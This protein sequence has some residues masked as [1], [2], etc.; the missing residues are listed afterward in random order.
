LDLTFASRP[1]RRQGSERQIRS[2]SVALVQ[3]TA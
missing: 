2:T 1:R 3:K